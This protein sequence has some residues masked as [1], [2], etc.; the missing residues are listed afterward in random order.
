MNIGRLYWFYAFDDTNR[1]R[2]GLFTGKYAING[3]AIVIEKNGKA[4]D[5][6]NID[7]DGTNKDGLFFCKKWFYNHE[8]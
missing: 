2:S 6:N 5:L 3:Y 8:E 7:A 4:T 1:I